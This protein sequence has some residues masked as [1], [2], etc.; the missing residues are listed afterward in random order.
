MR[1]IS[2]STSVEK[3]PDERKIRKNIVQW[4]FQINILK[5]IVLLPYTSHYTLQPSSGT[6]YSWI[7]IFFE[8]WDYTDLIL[9]FLSHMVFCL[10]IVYL[11]T[12]TI[13]FF[14]YSS[15]KSR[16]ITLPRLKSDGTQNFQVMKWTLKQKP[17]CV[18]MVVKVWS[19]VSLLVVKGCIW[20]KLTQLW[21][22]NQWCDS[23]FVQW[24]TWTYAKIYTTSQKLFIYLFVS[25]YSM[26]K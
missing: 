20:H 6:H 22:L 19:F 9:C 24:F 15:L 18:S 12:A 11:L 2:T 25:L 14:L 13:L 17:A 21:A 26:T 5:F 7:L 1:F 10:W 4:F 8:E 16:T 3:I 23:R